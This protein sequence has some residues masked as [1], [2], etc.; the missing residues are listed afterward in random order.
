MCPIKSI[1]IVFE[2]RICP[3]IM[4]YPFVKSAKVG[5]FCN[6]KIFSHIHKRVYDLRKFSN[7]SFTR[8]IEM[9]FTLSVLQTKNSNVNLKLKTNY[10]ST[11]VLVFVPPCKPT[12]QNSLVERVKIFLFDPF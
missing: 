8:V 6:S 5:I 9:V 1:N 10:S 4:C 11:P 7:D 3:L 2:V 12:Q